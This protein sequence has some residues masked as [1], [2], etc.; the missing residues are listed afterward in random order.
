M[1]RFA[2]EPGRI[3]VVDKDQADIRRILESTPE[4]MQVLCTLP[5]GRSAL[6][7]PPR[8]D[9]LLWMINSRLPDIAGCELLEMLRD[10]FH[11]VPVV[12]VAD[13]YSSED[14]L[15]ACRAGA[16]LYLCKPLEARVLEPWLGHKTQ[17]RG[18]PKV[19]MPLTPTKMLST[20][21]PI[22]HSDSDLLE[23]IP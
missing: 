1:F 5:D 10:R 8:P 15:H 20:H 7:M 11:G 12:I 3:V 16:T 22:D 13:R 14:E 18:D 4:A 19:P 17:V 23:E 21:P 9:D 6:R 2:Q